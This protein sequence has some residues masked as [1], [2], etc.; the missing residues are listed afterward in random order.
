MHVAV[1]RVKDLGCLLRVLREATRGFFETCL[2]HSI[3][4][5]DGIA[6]HG[7]AG[8]VA[9]RLCSARQDGPA[10]IAEGADE[11][12]VGRTVRAGLGVPGSWR[13]SP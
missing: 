12:G 7:A 6:N 5:Q 8:A 10:K 11:C 3:L 9:C 4:A 1:N 13:H 2:G